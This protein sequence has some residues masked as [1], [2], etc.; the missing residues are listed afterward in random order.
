MANEEN[1]LR[2]PSGFGKQQSRFTMM[3]RDACSPSVSDKTDTILNRIVLDKALDDEGLLFLIRLDQGILKEALKG[4]GEYTCHV[5]ANTIEDLYPNLS[6][7]ESFLVE[8][9]HSHL[10]KDYLNH[11][12]KSNYTTDNSTQEKESINNVMVACCDK[13]LSSLERVLDA[14]KSL[15]GI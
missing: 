9:D 2:N 6:G 5:I 13:S 12:V 11:D 15:G 1:L 3:I 7:Y 10:Q 8:N 4:R 14:R